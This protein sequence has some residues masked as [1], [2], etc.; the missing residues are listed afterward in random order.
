MDLSRQYFFLV[1]I[2]RT[3]ADTGGS[4]ELVPVTITPEPRRLFG[5]GPQYTPPAETVMVTP[6]QARKISGGSMAG[7]SL[8]DKINLAGI[9][10]AAGGITAMDGPAAAPAGGSR[11]RKMGSIM[12]PPTG[13]EMNTWAPFST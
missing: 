13:E 5:F 4:P 2:C 11:Q 8:V 1:Y 6:D 12:R 7:G 9:T 10:G 3:S